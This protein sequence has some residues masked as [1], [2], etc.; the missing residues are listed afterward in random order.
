MDFK[1]MK[2]SD[3]AQT[4]SAAIAEQ[5]GREIHVF[6]SSAKSPSSSH[7]VSATATAE[8]LEDD[9]Y[10]LTPED[11]YQLMSHKAGDQ[12]Q[13]LKTQKIREEEAAA[14]RARITKVAMYAWQVG[15]ICWK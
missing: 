10:D 6:K 7:V 9:F 8:E 13:I 11:Y 14:R 3:E 1:R 2:F 12:S 15:S 5:L 4:K